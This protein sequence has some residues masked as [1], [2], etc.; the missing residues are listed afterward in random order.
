M[1]SFCLNMR[2][3]DNTNLDVFVPELWSKESLAILEENMVAAGTVKRDFTNEIKNFGDTVHTRR[4]GE[5]DA[6]RK[7]NSE[8]VTVQDVTATNVAVVL[9]Q[10][11]HTSF[12]IKD[13]EQSKSFKDL[14]AVYLRPAMLAQAR[15]LDQVVLGQYAQFL[16]NSV[17]GLGLMTS[18]NAK[19][20]ILDA[21]AK[22]NDN[23]AYADGR[24]MI[25]NSN[26][27]TSMLKV[28]MFLSAEKVGDDGTAL[29]K[30]S[31]GE[32]LGFQF[33]MCQNMPTIR[34]NNMTKKTGAV[35]LTAG[36]P[37]GSTS[38]VVDGF[39]GTIAA[40]SWVTIGGDDTP[41][42]VTSSSATLGNATG[43]V[44]R[45]PLRKAVVNDAV[46]KAYTP[47]AINF[48][49]GYAVGY[50]GAITVDTFTVAPQTGQLV[51]FGDD[52]E[53]YTVIGT[54]TLTSIKL[55]RP[56]EAALANDDGVNL[57]PPGSY[58]FG[59]LRDSIALVVRPLELPRTGAIAGSSTYKDLAMRTVITYD[60]NKQGHLVTLD[61]LCGVKVLDANLGVVLCG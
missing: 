20:Y 11:V 28:D 5:L 50:A 31:L 18:T 43:I 58:N 2:P 44:L 47:G 27:E 49:D 3:M 16:A 29:R 22:M 56:L 14:V 26:S 36:Y 21:R 13:G 53:I 39:T 45:D 6:I 48:G 32:K 17:G 61:M 1:K 38:L 25:L 4:P 15:F 33:F 24:S 41:L 9:N 55:D 23:K 40:G 12:I 10:H 46:I 19:D 52:T 8:N 30:A 54:P 57:G 34:D 42:R 60:G 35:N 51:S 7:T 37:A 59:Y